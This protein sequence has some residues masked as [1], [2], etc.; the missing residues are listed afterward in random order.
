MT[1][2][3]MTLLLMVVAA[4]A[5]AD[6]ISGKVVSVADGDTITILDSLKKQH[7]IR[8]AGIDAPEKTQAFGNVS[9]RSLS[10]LVYGKQVDVEWSK[11]DRYGRTV[12][13][14]IIG[15]VDVNFE[16]IGRG[17]AWFYIKYQ[18]E[19]K[20]QDRLDY[21]GAQDSAQQA[22]LGLWSDNNS[23]PPWDYRKQKY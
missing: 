19:L 20:P 15:T 9:K 22:G 7:K 17:M 6:L 2:T 12:G 3:L 8:L 23:I 18:N 13:K 21:A 11:R 10:E 4:T 5:D 14:V 1:K 16:Q